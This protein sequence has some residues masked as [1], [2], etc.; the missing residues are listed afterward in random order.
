MQEDLRNQHQ[1]N[2]VMDQ[3]N[4]C[5][6]IIKSTRHL[7][8][9][10]ILGPG[11]RSRINMDFYWSRKTDK[12]IFETLKNGYS[13]LILGN[14]LAGKTRAL[15][16]ALKK[17]D[18][19]TVM[20]PHDTFDP[21]AVLK[22]PENK[23]QRF[24]AL[25]DDIDQFLFNYSKENL[26]KFLFRLMKENIII[27][28]TCRQ[29]NEYLNFESFISHK[30]RLNF[31]QVFI[32]R[33]NNYQVNEFIKFIET[34]V[35]KKKKRDIILDKKA[36]DRNIGS[37]FMN[38]TVMWNRYR[39]LEKRIEK[40][41]LD[42]PPNLPG[43]ILKALKY[44]YYTE[45]TEGKSFFS[46]EKIKD[47][48]ERHLLGKKPKSKLQK[49]KRQQPQQQW[50]QQLDQF[51][52]QAKDEFTSSE[53]KN[54]LALLSSTEYELNFFELDEPYIRI[55]EVYLERLIE[56]NM[57]LLRI[58]TILKETYKGEDIR[59][60]GFLNNVYGYTRLINL[61]RTTGE[62][63]NIL[64]RLNEWG[65]QP[66]VVTYT[67]LINKAANFKEALPFLDKMIEQGIKPDEISFTALVNKVENFDDATSFLDKMIEHGLKPNVI[68][69][70][71][72]INKT[73]TFQQTYTI[74]ERMKTQQVRP[75]NF[76][77]GLLIK[78]V[79]QNPRQALE[80]L[81]ETYRETTIFSN[82]L[83][84]RIITEACK[85]D[86]S[87]KELILSHIP[88]ISRQAD[89]V[90]FHYAHTM[91]FIRTT[92]AALELLEHIKEKNFDYYN[93]KANCLKKNDFKQALELYQ[94]ALLSAKDKKQRTITLNNAAQLIVDHKQ[95]TLYSTAIDYCKEALS[96][97]PF[98]Q[99]PYPGHL[100]IQ[101][102][103]L[104]SPPE[105]VEKNLSDIMRTYRI[106][107]RAQKVE[108]SRS[109]VGS[110]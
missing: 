78:K 51:L 4:N 49:A 22:L 16:E 106:T 83:F 58:I 33:M 50:H 66:T 81:F 44:F 12:E 108:G 42:I 97:R 100:L 20:V 61:A 80:T 36:F 11:I 52:S 39:D 110:G 14:S 55:E 94:T 67:S 92:S 43:T 19:T 77:I 72:L 107:K 40:Y 109:S 8:P 90:I 88:V 13:L 70:T 79:N 1:K 48:C 75:N 7:E 63:F 74:L 37:Y 47:F 46:I 103:I 17:L 6:K 68:D 99:F 69:F 71:L 82:Y 2:E 98:S 27:A 45:N 84:N 56:R 30:I 64:T 25:F 26:E 15:Y 85:A 24:I 105:E 76:T 28:A 89:P 29:G 35:K 104:Q 38:L 95:E 101:L 3:A 21:G 96:L 41:D 32:N 54:V 65:I 18:N 10:D 57:N 62:A 73:D 34:S 53:W 59:K 91:E 23:G 93:I 5:F 102:T 60:Y 86:T 31:K 9:K 87:C